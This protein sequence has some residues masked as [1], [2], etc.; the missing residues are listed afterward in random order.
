M[1]Q[2]DASDEGL[3]AVLCQ[4]IEGN[5]VVVQYMSRT[6][7]PAEKKWTVREKESRSI[8]CEVL[9]PYVI[10]SKFII[11]THHQ[12]LKWLIEAKFPARLVRWALRLSEYY[13]EIRY[14]KG[15]KNLNADAVS[16]IQINS[17]EI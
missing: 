5:K 4:E 13:F 10:R 6:L 7:H 1:I 9:R 15:N 14:K 2:T 11:E 16:L 3:G 8:A 17:N 12:S